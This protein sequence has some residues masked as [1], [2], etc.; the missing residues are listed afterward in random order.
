MNK[1]ITGS[2]SIDRYISAFHYETKILLKKLREVIRKAA[3]E[4]EETISYAMPTFTMEGNLVHFAAYKNHIGFYPAPSGITAFKKDLSIYK[5]SKGAVQ[6]PLDKPLPLNLISRI[7]KFRVNENLEKAKKKKLI[8]SKAKNNLRTCSKGH[9]YY[10]SSDCRPVCEK[11]LKPNEGFL[12]MLSAPARRALE[13]KGITTLNKLSGYSEEEI[14]KLHGMGPGS[15]PKLRGALKKLNLSFRKS[16]LVV[17]EK[18]SDKESVNK[19]IAKLDPQTAEI[20]QAIR[21]IFL[22]SHKEIAERIKWNNPS[23]YFTGEMKPFDP[24]EYKRE[25]AVFNLYKG[26]IM[27]VFPSGARVKDTSGLLEGDYKDGRRILIIKNH[28]DFKTKEKNLHK[29]IKEWIRTIDK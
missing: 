17:A 12:S 18:S 15:I 29:V 26:R 8:K 9:K 4:A 24:K 25:I 7:V 28:D 14:L 11:E 20:V 5:S 21:K 10:K 1:S 19:H 2:G 23:F 27:L 3:P 16:S 13:N 6:F 22:N